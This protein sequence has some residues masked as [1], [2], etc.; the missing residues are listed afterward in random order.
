MDP[1]ISQQLL[2]PDGPDTALRTLRG[3]RWILPCLFPFGHVFVSGSAAHTRGRGWQRI[4]GVL[5]LVEQE[6]GMGRQGGRGWSC[7]AS[8]E[9][10]T[11]RV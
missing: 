3:C 6:D 4:H 1:P 9:A 11:W 7:A 10:C 2:F 5:P 8:E